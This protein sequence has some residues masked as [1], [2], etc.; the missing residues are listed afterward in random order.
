MRHKVDLR[1]K[2]NWVNLYL[3]GK[4]KQLCVTAPFLHC[5][6]LY[7]R[8]IS[9][10]KSLGAYIGRGNLTQ[11]LLRYQLVGGAYISRGLYM[12]GPIFG[13]YGILQFSN[14]TY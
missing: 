10:Y 13:I 6:I 4:Y 7:L 1:Y 8:E 9:K 2:I 14:K 3:E 11:G 5:F 12:E